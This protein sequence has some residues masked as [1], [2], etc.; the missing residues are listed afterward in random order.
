MN[1]LTATLIFITCL[2][3]TVGL[4]KVCQWLQPRENAR[5]SIQSTS[6][7]QGGRP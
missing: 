3:A 2:A 6:T 1:D 5:Q 4:V 7:S